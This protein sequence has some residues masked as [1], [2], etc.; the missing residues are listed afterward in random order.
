[1]DL[2]IAGKTVLV[3]GSS[4]GTGEAIAQGFAAEGAHILVHGLARG[5]AEPVAAALNEAGH[6]ASAIGGD[7]TTEAGAA[8]AAE[9]ALAAAAGRIDILIN[10]YGTGE[11]GFWFDERTDSNAWIDVYQKNVLSAMRMIRTLT[12][13]MKMR[14][15]GRIIQLGT[16]GSTMPNARMPHYYAS[17]GALANMTVSLMLELAETGITVN[18]VSPGLI[19]TREVEAMYRKIAAERDW[20]D[21]WREIERHVMREFMGNPTGRIALT[22]EVADLV[23]FLASDR[24][25]MIN[26]MNIRI[27]G[28]G[29]R[30]VS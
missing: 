24:A 16:I 25:A 30:M 6:K 22:S 9:D 18:T 19:K 5:D 4:R 8:A 20:G 11:R 1:M 12:P 15:W 28:G 2:G 14:G 29:A 7:I 10:N 3:T 21:D 27:D 26:G 23:L 13:Q 17:K